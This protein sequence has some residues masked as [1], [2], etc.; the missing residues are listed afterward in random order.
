[1]SNNDVTCHVLIIVYTLYDISTRERA[2]WRNGNPHCELYC[3]AKRERLREKRAT[4]CKISRVI[5]QS[6]YEYWLTR[7]AH[8]SKMIECW[9]LTQSITW[10]ALI[11][12]W[13]SQLWVIFISG[14][15]NLVTNNNFIHQTFLRFH[16]VLAHL[17]TSRNI[18]SDINNGCAVNRW[19]PA[20]TRNIFLFLVSELDSGIGVCKVEKRND[21]LFRE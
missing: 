10:K 16:Q 5:P 11:I 1:M 6:N 20:H 4:R 18:R 15:Y 14:I 7:L 12:I 17:A 8:F 2:E 9:L 19:Q 13:V 21:A 3:P